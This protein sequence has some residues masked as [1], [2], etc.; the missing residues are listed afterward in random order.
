MKAPVS[1]NDPVR[2]ALWKAKLSALE[3]AE[4]D[5]ADKGKGDIRGNNAQS[6]DESHGERSLVH[7]AARCNTETSKSFL[8][9]KVSVAATRGLA[10]ADRMVK[11]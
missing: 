10:T 11:D 6:A 3:H 7:V 4:H 8:P 1:W 9:E 2:R 5:G